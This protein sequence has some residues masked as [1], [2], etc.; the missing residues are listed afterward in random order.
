MAKILIID[1]DEQIR[2][3]CRLVFEAMEHEVSAEPTLA[4]GLAAIE[5][6]DFDV[7]YLD[8]DCPT[9]SACERHR[10]DQPNA[11]ARRR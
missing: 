11:N 5:H 8:V 7:V 6:G 4:R 1:D 2:Q 9:A 10:A 3:V